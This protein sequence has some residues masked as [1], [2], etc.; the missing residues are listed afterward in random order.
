MKKNNAKPEE[1]QYGFVSEKIKAR[2]IDQ[3]KVIRNILVSIVSAV[4]FGLVACITFYLLSPFVSGYFE[5]DDDT[6]QFFEPIVLTE[7]NDVEEMLPED[8]M[9]SSPAAEIEIEPSGSD[10]ETEAVKELVE[11][12]V[13]SVE[14]NVS[15]YQDMQMKL[16][17]IAQSTANFLVKVTPVK[18][19]KDWLNN[20]ISIKSELTGIIVAKNDSSVYVLTYS[21][22]VKNQ[23]M[24]AVTFGNGVSSMGYLHSFDS[25]TGLAI[26]NVPNENINAATLEYIRIASLGSS[27]FSQMLGYPIIAVGSPMGTYGS[28]NFGVITATGLKIEVPDNYYK[29]FTTDIYGSTTANGVIINYRGSVLGIIDTR[30]SAADMRNLISAI[31]ISE[32]KK[33]IE[34]LS[35]DK[36]MVYCG[37]CGENMSD[38]EAWLRK[39]TKG[40]F[41]TSVKM[42]SPAMNAGIQSGDIVNKIN[43]DL[44]QSFPEY[45]MLLNNYNPGDVITVSVYRE[46]PEG[47]KLLDFDVKLELLQ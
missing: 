31:G 11:G 16:G 35:N 44:V 39:V 30:Y 40:I 19:E 18:S 34:T 9:L 2:P 33:T 27:N 10:I 3:S 26:I 21:M 12:I 17:E 47:Y 28:V 13:N 46:A 14:F 25:N 4:V 38:D 42:D 29:R 15:D 32:I 6:K 5:K 43:G 41:I 8:M 23:E 1:Q 37:I 7:A 45:I 22:N 20:L 24:L 36:E